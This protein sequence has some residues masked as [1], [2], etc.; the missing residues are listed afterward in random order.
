[1]PALMQRVHTPVALRLLLQT[2]K[3]ITLCLV[4]KKGKMELIKTFIYHHGCLVDVAQLRNRGS[5]KIKS[6]KVI[7]EKAS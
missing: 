4:C 7:H 2:G 3:D 1:M 5:P 6:K